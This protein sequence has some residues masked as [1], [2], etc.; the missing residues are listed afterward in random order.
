MRTSDKLPEECR[1]EIRAMLDR[2]HKVEP[3]GELEVEVDD[4]LEHFNFWEELGPFMLGLRWV[5]NDKEG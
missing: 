3:G 1:E 5:L 4:Y 2:C